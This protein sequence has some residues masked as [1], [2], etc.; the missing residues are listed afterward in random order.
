[1]DAAWRLAWALPLVLAV[2]VVAMLVLRRVLVPA[3]PARR[4]IQ[5]M[6]L[7]ESLELSEH[8]RVHII[9]VDG[10]EFVVLESAQQATLQSVSQSAGPSR[11]TMQLGPSWTRRFLKAS[12]R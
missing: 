7:C 6:S 5:R 8:T 12:H 10:R 4:Q 9:E 2:G 11:S 3:L 1:M